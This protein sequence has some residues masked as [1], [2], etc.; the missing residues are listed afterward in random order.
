[1]AD[2]ARCI[3][4]VWFEDDRA[5]QEWRPP[6]FFVE[7]DFEDFAG[8]LQA[9]HDDEIIVG[10]VLHAPWAKG[11][12]GVREVKGRRPIAFRGRAT[13]RMELPSCRF[14]ETEEGDE[15]V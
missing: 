2:A 9:M 8:A 13:R 7:T 6:F 3:V 12:Y 11:Q 15:H 5:E 1:M 10:D 4:Q 14:I